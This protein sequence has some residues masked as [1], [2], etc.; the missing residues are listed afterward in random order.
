MATDRRVISS[1]AKPSEENGSLIS[2]SLLETRNLK[3]N[4]SR[5][6]LSGTFE[7]FI[8]FTERHL[9][10]K[11]ETAKLSEN[12]AKKTIKAEHLILNWFKSTGTL[13]LQ[14]SQA[15]AC[16]AILIQLLAAETE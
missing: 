2:P 6:S 9:D 14:G 7:E 15:A 13:Q 3:G 5:L 8:D 16:K 4:E 1:S 11:P 12:E 10:I